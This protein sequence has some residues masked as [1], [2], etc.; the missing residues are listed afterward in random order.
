MDLRVGFLDYVESLRIRAKNVRTDQIIR[1]G[2]RKCYIVC[3][4][5]RQFVRRP[6]SALN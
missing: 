1:N 3:T 4:L 2:I 6:Q 5:A